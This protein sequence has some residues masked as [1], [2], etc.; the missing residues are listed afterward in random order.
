MPCAHALRPS[1]RSVLLGASPT[2]ALTLPSSGRAKGYALVPPLKSN[3]RAL[4]LNLVRFRFAPV[5]RV[6]VHELARSHAPVAHR[7]YSSRGFDQRRGC[8][9]V[10]LLGVAFSLAKPE[11]NSLAAG[12]SSSLAA[13]CSRGGRNFILSSSGPNLKHEY[14]VQYNAG[15]GLHALRARAAAEFSSSSIGCVTHRRPNPAFKRTCQGL[16]PCLAA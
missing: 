9:L 1:S 11:G 13:V 7:S 2:G 5:R 15:S 8:S 16:R 3:V 6:F 4:A 12:A 14:E 10:A